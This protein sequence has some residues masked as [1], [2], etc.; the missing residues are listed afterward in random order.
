VERIKCDGDDADGTQLE[1]RLV[2]I[3]GSPRIIL[4]PRQIIPFPG[5]MDREC[6]FLGERNALFAFARERTA[7]GDA[8]RFL[9]GCSGLPEGVFLHG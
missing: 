6:L 7:G 4:D 1:R 3:L 2:S 5:L 9:G 8:Y